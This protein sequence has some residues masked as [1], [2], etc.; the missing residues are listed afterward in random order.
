MKKILI[1]VSHPDDEIL[2]CGGTI[3]KHASKKDKVYVYFTHEGSSAR[4][5]DPNNP[6]VLLEIKKRSDIA[7]NLAKKFKYKVIGFGD[8]RNLY[9]NQV[10]VIKSIRKISKIIN[11]IK[12]DIIYTHFNNDMN[13]DHNLT[14]NNVISACRPINFLVKEIY[15]MEIPSSTEWKHSNNIF[16]PNL[17]IN[18]NIKQKLKM[19]EYYKSE[20]RKNPHPRSKNKIKALAMYRG[21]QAGL[22]YAESFMIYRKIIS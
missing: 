3:Y 19:I 18:I 5:I 13:P 12:P 22:N 4:F 8:N 10:D 11:S 14:H 2:G 1:I 6:E 17:F 21:A 20:L 7:T 9:P 15:L 16:A